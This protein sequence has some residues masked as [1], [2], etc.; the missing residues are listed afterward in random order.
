[1]DKET[2]APQA[3]PAAEPAKDPVILKPDDSLH[4]AVGNVNLNNVISETKLEKAAQ[5][6]E[7]K[8]QDFM[9]T[10][11][12]EFGKLEA[13]Y[14]KLGDAAANPKELLWQIA[15]ISLEIKGVSGLCGY[16]MMPKIARSLHE[17]TDKGTDMDERK[18]TI[19][20]AHI[21]TLR[22]IFEK[23]K[24]SENTEIAKTLVVEFDN[25]N[26]K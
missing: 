7:E 3:V 9:Q 1:M 14:S 23:G 5:V 15:F 26:K 20:K 6:V 17:C 24:E 4:K 21:D 25:L 22:Y 13:V 18:K 2:P 19:I 16:T 8:T 10:L 11:K 12:S